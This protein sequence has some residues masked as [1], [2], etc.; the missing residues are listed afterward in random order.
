MKHK[1]LSIKPAI[2]SVLLLAVHILNS[3]AQLP[4]F[5]WVKGMGGPATDVAKA[6]VSDARGNVYTTGSFKNKANFKPGATPEDT[7]YF[8]ATVQDIFVTRHGADGKLIW[9][10]QMGGAQAEG[11]AITIDAK[12]EYIYL[13]GWFQGNVT[14]DPT[15][16]GGSLTSQG[17]GHDA[18]ILKMDSSGRLIWVKQYTST[19]GADGNGIALG[20]SGNIYTTGL[21]K[22]TTDFDP[23][24]GDKDTFKLVSTFVAKTEDA[25]TAALDNNGKFLWAK[26]YGGDKADVGKAIAVDE[27]ENIYTT[28]HFQGTVDFDPGPEFKN[29]TAVGGSDVFLC[30]YDVK[31]SFQWVKTIGGSSYDYGYGVTTGPSGNVYVGGGF[32]GKTAFNIAGKDTLFLTAAGSYDIFVYAIDA[33]GGFLWAK[34]YGSTGEDEVYGIHCDAS[35]NIYITGCFEKTI[36]FGS[37]KGDPLITS[38]GGID[39]FIATLNV[40]GSPLAARSMGSTGADIGFGIHANAAGSVYAVGRFTGN[41][42]FNASPVVSL[43]SAGNEDIF[44][45]KMGISCETS[46]QVTMNGCD[47]VV[48][49]GKT[50]KESGVYQYAF[51]NR[52]GCDST[53]TLNLTIN[54]STSSQIV[55]SAC[56]SYEL[57]KKIYTKSGKYTDVLRNAKGCDSVITLDLTI[58]P[59]PSRTIKETAC[60]QYVFNGKTYSKT[61]VYTDT[62]PYKHPSDVC[63]SII[64][65]DLTILQSTSHTIKEK[66]C[67]Q[68]V[69]NKKTYTSSGIYRDTLKNAAGCD[70][71]VTLDLTISHSS[72]NTLNIRDCDSYTF[73]GKVYTTSGTFRDTLKTT[74]GCDSVIT[75]NLTINYS[76]HDTITKEACGKFTFGDETYTQ[77]GF[78]QH[79]AQYASGCDSIVTLKLTVNQLDLTLRQDNNTLTA[80]DGATAYQWLDCDNGRTPISGA[81]QQSFHSDKKGNFS[82]V[83][84][85]DDCRDTTVCY[86]IIGTTGI[87]DY[88]NANDD[89]YLYPNPATA[90]IQISGKNGMRNT[91]ITLFN[92]VGQALVRENNFTGSD[93]ILNTQMLASG[94]YIIELSEAG[95][96]RR[97]KFIKQ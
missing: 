60:N 4:T 57:N 27:D 15:T 5:Q 65:L 83:I 23:G 32:Q 96:N 40:K 28:G 55:A 35:E 94:V 90:S 38:A 44:L 37:G 46:S 45:Y 9:T 69:Y 2:L 64:T 88:S 47:S 7:L 73:N 82:V 39:I 49:N 21:F 22:G 13:T 84:T 61:G 62:I 11:T 87:E 97:L 74:G 68:Y 50:H 12:G 86:A 59:A 93:Y 54:K 75:L 91:T 58:N 17:A 16:K 53:V 29:F 6:V 43:L 92:A 20:K 30:K 1:L 95:I 81:T 31:G 26:G 76:T 79:T 3:N 66:A 48:Y 80:M 78:Y 14:F 52:A 42:T 77:S 67:D 70:S 51:T 34:N 8:T 24:T 63:D 56:G 36:S 33:K 25:Y 89:F 19:N 72:S 18:F 71:I 41:A 10:R 85:L